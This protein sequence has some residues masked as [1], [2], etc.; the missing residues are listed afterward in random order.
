[1]AEVFQNTIGGK[2]AAL[3]VIDADSDTGM[4]AL[5]KNFN[6]AVTETACEILGVEA[7]VKALKKGKSAGVDNVPA[8]LVQEGG[9]TMI[10]A[11]T[12]ICNTI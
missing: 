3:A 12:T 8:E 2:F 6:T 11:L 10:D 7:A 1:M 4:D 5:I 9:E